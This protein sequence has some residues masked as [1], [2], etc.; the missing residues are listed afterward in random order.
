MVNYGKRYRS[1][2]RVAT[3]LAE[4]AVN[5]PFGKRMVKKQQIRWS[6]QGAHMLMQVRTAELNG[7]LPDRLR[8]PF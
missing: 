8:A 3:T 6:L 7:E 4:S 1:G 2:L 5:S